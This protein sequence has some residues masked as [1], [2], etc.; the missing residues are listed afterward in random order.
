MLA[1]DQ[2]LGPAQ[3]TVNDDGEAEA[4]PVAAT[5]TLEVT[6]QQAEMITLATTLGSLSLVLNSVRD[7]G[8]EGDRQRPDRADRRRPRRGASAAPLA[9]S[10]RS[11][12]T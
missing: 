4:A 5:A 1:M 3:P 9:R 7:G 2:R 12:P 10:R 11:I 8:D 6:P